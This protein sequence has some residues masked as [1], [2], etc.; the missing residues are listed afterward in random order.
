MTVLESHKEFIPITGTTLTYLRAF[1]LG[2][3]HCQISEV[4]HKLRTADQSM[5][6][7]WGFPTF[8]VIAKQDQQFQIYNS[9]MA[10]DE[11]SR[12]YPV[13]DCVAYIAKHNLHKLLQDT[14][15]NNTNRHNSTRIWTW[16][17]MQKIRFG[18]ATKRDSAVREIK[19]QRGDWSR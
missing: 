6:F 16:R 5:D 2:I 10:A 11:V 9:G 14:L 1:L 7:W 13:I 17:L 3:E 12:V 4:D 15:D 18:Y 19:A 8:L